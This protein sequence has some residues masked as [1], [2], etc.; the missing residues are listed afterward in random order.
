[1]RTCSLEENGMWKQTNLIL[2][3]INKWIHLRTILSQAKQKQKSIHFSLS[4]S[5]SHY[6]NENEDKNFYH[7]N[8][9]F[10]DRVY[11]II[12][13]RYYSKPHFFLKLMLSSTVSF[14][15]LIKSNRRHRSYFVFNT[16]GILNFLKHLRHRASLQLFVSEN[17]FMNIIKEQN[18]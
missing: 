12:F 3:T 7:H 9:S 8:T 2:I 16:A 6:F 10:I 4:S 14:Y 15:H 13:K 1:M 18:Y 11:E 5:L 17:K